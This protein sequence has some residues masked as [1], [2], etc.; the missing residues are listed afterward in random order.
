MKNADN[1]QTYIHR[2]MQLP[3]EDRFAWTTRS[4]FD[5]AYIFDVGE[6]YEKAISIG[7]KWITSTE[8]PEFQRLCQQD[9]D[10]M[11]ESLRS[12]F[13][14]LCEDWLYWPRAKAL[15]YVEYHNTPSTYDDNTLSCTVGDKVVTLCLRS[16]EAAFAELAHAGTELLRLVLGRSDQRNL[17]DRL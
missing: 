17:A 10:E 11:R 12:Q 2:F 15:L 6:K 9:M 7:Q 13:A 16:S 4:C 8:M 1:R 5:I 3:V 14:T